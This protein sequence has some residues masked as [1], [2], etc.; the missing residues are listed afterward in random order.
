M[1][2]VYNRHSGKPVKSGVLCGHMTA[3]SAIAFSD[4]E[5]VLA[6]GEL[7]GSIRL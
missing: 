6:S 3:V 1:T 4:D 5:S 7:D 2:F